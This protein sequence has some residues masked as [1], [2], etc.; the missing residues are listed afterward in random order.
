MRFSSYAFQSNGKCSS[1]Y[2]TFNHHVVLDTLLPSQTY[3]YMVGDERDGWS[4][5]LTFKSAPSEFKPFS[6]A[7][8][9][10]LGNQVL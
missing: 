9:G 7:V 8:F 3:Y 1:Y 5:E 6:F 2:E 10:D 4:E